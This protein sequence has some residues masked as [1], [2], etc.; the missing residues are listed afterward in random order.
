LRSQREACLRHAHFCPGKERLGS[1]CASL[2]RSGTS[3]HSQP[4]PFIPLLSSSSMS[5]A[6][7]RKAVGRKERDK[8]KRASLS[9]E[10]LIALNVSK[11]PKRL[12]SKKRARGEFA[13]PTTSLG[14]DHLP[15]VAR[16]PS[17][18]PTI[19]LLRRTAASLLRSREPRSTRESP[20]RRERRGR[21][22]M[23]ESG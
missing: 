11:N 23:D 10:V 16:A 15:R 19:S 9:A 2:R 12:P 7:A 4:L 14:S 22:G 18:P 6:Q 13:F 3:L 20:F 1:F 17:F 8:L 21:E 5:S